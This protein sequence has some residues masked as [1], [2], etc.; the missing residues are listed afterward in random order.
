VNRRAIPTPRQQ[1]EALE[2]LIRVAPDQRAQLA[3]LRRLLVAQQMLF[4]I[5][6]RR[7]SDKA[8][9][10]EPRLASPRPP[11]GGRTKPYLSAKS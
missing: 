9:P 8:P 7:E 3:R 2:H 1:L 10:D 5:V 6:G 11:A 4:E